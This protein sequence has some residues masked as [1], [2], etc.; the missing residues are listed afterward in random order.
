MKKPAIA[1]PWHTVLCDDS[2]TY[3]LRALNA[4][5]ASEG[6]QRL[7]LKWII[8]RLCGTYDLSY[9]P[10]SERDT[11]FAEGKR[12]VGLQLIHELNRPIVEKKTI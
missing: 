12:R 2:V 3:A 8:E 6:Q 5:K 7:A 9:R 1:L 10:E 11:V 4:G